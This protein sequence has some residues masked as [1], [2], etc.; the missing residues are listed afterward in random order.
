MKRVTT[1]EVLSTVTIGI[2]AGKSKM[3]PPRQCCQP[4]ET[5]SKESLL[6]ECQKDA[7]RRYV[8]RQPHRMCVSS[9]DNRRDNASAEHRRQEQGCPFPAEPWTECAE[10]DCGKCDE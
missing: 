7:P 8:E 5:E 3:G 9:S 1:L 6:T 4:V 2:V 10:I